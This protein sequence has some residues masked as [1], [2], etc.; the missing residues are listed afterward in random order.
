MMN[1]SQ[2]LK[3]DLAETVSFIEAIRNAN[4]ELQQN[5]KDLSKKHNV[6]IDVLADFLGHFTNDDDKTS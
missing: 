3:Q 6:D 1:C 5:V 4:V 2:E